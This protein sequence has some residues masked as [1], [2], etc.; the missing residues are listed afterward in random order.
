MRVTKSVGT[1]LL[2]ALVGLGLVGA[3]PGKASA[4]HY[5]WYGGYHYPY[6]W[7]NRSYNPYSA[8]SPY[9]NWYGSYGGYYG[10]YPYYTWSRAYPWGWYY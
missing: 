4:W 9:H 3:T 10:R 2:L 7:G 6:Y 5:R 1:T 8:Y